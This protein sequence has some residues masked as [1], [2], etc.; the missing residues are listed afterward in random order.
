MK[1]YLSF[2]TF[3]ITFD[4]HTDTSDNKIGVVVFQEKKPVALFSR[5]LIDTHKGT[6]LLRR[7]YLIFWRILSNVV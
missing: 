3:D 1:K 7:N 5:K 4:I 6:P 2:P